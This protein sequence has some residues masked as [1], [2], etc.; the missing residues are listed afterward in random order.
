[1]RIHHIDGGTMRPFGGRLLDGV[2]GITRRAEMVCHCV[3]I[4]LDDRLVLIETGIGEGAVRR[5]DEWLGRR[6]IRMTRPV[7]DLERTVARRIEALGYRREDVTDIVLTHLDLDHAGGLA[8]FPQARVHV[9]GE[10]LRALDGKFGPREKFRY[11]A[12]QFAHGPR[13]ESYDELGEPWFGFGA[14]R[15]LRGLPAELLI[16]PLAGHTRGHAGIAIDT[17]A[18]WKFAVG[19]AYF[20]PGQ[21]DLEHPHQ[22]PGA[23]LF[24]R[25]VQTVGPARIDN[26]ERL[27]ELLRGHGDE[28]EVFSAHNAVEL[29]ALQSAT[30]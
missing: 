28:V 20:H 22:P 17:G 24:E 4:E 13:W 26:Q 9:Y 2:G 29:R 14:V 18:G 7:L 25:L 30:V 23:A 11:R 19:D 21:L 10:E 8:E 27:R 3:L 15:Q 12:A 5:P 16:I 6:F 1:M